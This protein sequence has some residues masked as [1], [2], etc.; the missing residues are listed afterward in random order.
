MHFLHE[1][2]LNRGLGSR[3]GSKALGKAKGHSATG[4][5]MVSIRST[6]CELASVVR[7]D[8]VRPE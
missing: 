1:L 8:L 3:W 6:I 7:S 2:R 5:E 4:E